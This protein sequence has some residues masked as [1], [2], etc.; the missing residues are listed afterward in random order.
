MC[1]VTFETLGTFTSC[2]VSKKR[3]KLIDFEKKKCYKRTDKQMHRETAL[4]GRENEQKRTINL[5]SLPQQV[6]NLIVLMHF[7]FLIK[8][9]L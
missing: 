9:L 3:K 8:I 2:P 6:H 1:S 7:T 5:P 4:K